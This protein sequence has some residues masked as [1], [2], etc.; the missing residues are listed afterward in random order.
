MSGKVSFGKGDEMVTLVTATRSSRPHRDFRVKDQIEVDDKIIVFLCRCG[1]AISEKIDVDSIAKEISGQ[2]D[3]TVAYA[4]DFACSSKGKEE[5][6]RILKECGA[7][8]FVIGGCSPKTHELIFRDLAIE[9]GINPFMFEI[10]NI[11]EQCAFV[12]RKE[13][14]LPKA[15][16]LVTAAIAKCRLL[17]PSPYDR[18]PVANQRVL[19]IGNGITAI[20]AATKI[21]EEGIEVTIVNPETAFNL[22]KSG[23]ICDGDLIESMQARLQRLKSNPFVKIFTNVE[24]VDFSGHA[25][26]FRALVSIGTEEID[27]ECGAVVLAVDS[28]P[29]ENSDAIFKEKGM[30][31][32][33]LLEKS[34]TAKTDNQRRIVIL[35]TRNENSS[36]CRINRDTDVFEMAIRIRQ[37]NPKSEITIICRDVR[38]YGL[39]ELTFKRAQEQNIRV[40]RTETEV[41]VEKNEGLD[42]LVDDASSGLTLR[43][44]ADIVVGDV[45]KIPVGTTAI[46][47]VLRIPLTGDGFFRKTQVK[48]KPA[49]TIREGIFLCGS[50]TEYAPALEFL[51]DAHTAASRA[52]ALVKSNYIEIGGAVAEVNPEKCSACL[53]CVRSCPYEAPFIGEAG[54]AEIELE[55]CRGCG[56]CV[57][58]C[59]S[60]AIEMYFYSDAQLTAQVRSVIRGF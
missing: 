35:L 28:I 15:K 33:S 18:I 4:L 29:E 24:I 23:M 11:R 40:I 31:P 52:A 50:A 7:G 46:A 2:D 1:G 21:V 14:A 6:K 19:V 55:K 8:R 38:T 51:L 47:R 58:I 3:K 49:A 59:P 27:I 43:I 54:K 45:P 36:F 16:A 12:H 20:E 25:G 42:V 41:R 5:I 56:I 17:I 37:L 26:R 53:T 48:L 34:E 60:R 44:P 32:L 13:D 22:E 39:H 57:G 30:I 9:V 10:A